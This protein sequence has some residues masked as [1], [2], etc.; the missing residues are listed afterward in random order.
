VTASA[1]TSRFSDAT[2]EAFSRMSDQEFI[3]ETEASYGEVISQFSVVDNRECFV[4][5]E[6]LIV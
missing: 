4:V 2:I 3:G 5:E 6:E 1:V